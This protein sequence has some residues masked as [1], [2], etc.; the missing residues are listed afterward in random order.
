VSPTGVPPR[1]VRGP[2]S[3]PRIPELAR[4]AASAVLAVLAVLTAGG[5]PA[6]GRPTGPDARA[7]LRYTEYGI[8]HILARD[9]AGLG[10][11]YG[12]AEARDNIC[13]LAGAYLTVQAQRAR[14]FGADGPGDSALSAA[15]N[16]LDSDLYF[17]WI[18]DSGVVQRAV[19]QPAPLGVEPD[20]RRMVS[21][22][23]A[24]YN[25]YLRE[26]GVAGLPDPTCRGAAW[27]RPIT[28]LDVYTYA[29]ALTISAGTGAIAGGL[30]HAQPPAP[31]A[32]AV[33]AASPGA[34]RLAT[35]LPGAGTGDLGSNAVAVGAQGTTSGGAVLLG[36][37]HYPWQG[38]RRFWQSQLTIPGVFDVAGAGPFGLPTV[39][40][41]HN[42]DVAWS[43]TVSVAATFGLYEVTTVP[44]RPTAYLVDGVPEE[45]TSQVVSV[46]VRVSG[47][48]TTVVR[49]LWSTRYGPVI[50]SAPG[51]PLPW[52]TSAYALRDANA[53]NL[54]MLNTWLELGRANNTGQVRDALTRT[55]G[56]PWMNTLAVDRYGSAL[57]A[58]VQ[59]V[60]NVSDQLAG[61]CSTPLGAQVFPTSGLSIL[62]GGRA[63]CAWGTDPDAVQPGSLGPARLPVLARRDFVANSNDGPWL[64]NP[65]QPLTGFPRV[66]GPVGTR[67]SFRTQEAILAVQRRL[68][69]T[70]GLP[71]R[72][73]DAKTMRQVL[74]A[75]RSRVAELAAADT[76]HMCAAF[77]DGRADSYAG[78]VSVAPG[79]AAL[80]HWD[81]G[82][83]LDS[84]GSLLF[85]RFV[86]RLAAVPA[87]PWARP[88]DPADPLHTPAGLEVGSPAVRRAFGD[89]AADL[90][91]A[92]IPLDA[93]LDR[94]QYVTDG[95]RRIPIHG[96]PHSLGVL[97]VVTPVWDPAAGN[98]Q[99]VHGSSFIQVVEFGAG[100]YPRV[101]TVLTYSQSSDPTSAHHSDQT[102]LFSAGQWVTE[103]FTERDIMA[104]PALR[105]QVLDQ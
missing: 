103:R 77:P 34:A 100:R 16:S 22:Y 28:E 64:T 68:A 48:S 76:A 75:D 45:M 84:A 17:Q 90:R 40:I 87:A 27:V 72:G 8:P 20:V 38:S 49:R 80:A 98:T 30:V 74:L 71:G 52:S 95:P 15:A 53:G 29:Y 18:R 47:G 86:V 91:A 56:L 104:S 55:Q 96:A 10:L 37:P 88:F 70:D 14:Y 73:F 63:S 19:A 9:F 83:R 6:V 25:R 21:G 43:H 51:V 62:D 60:A 79:C 54:R 36:N 102:R 33:H 99:I 59:V 105:V 50:D 66:V 31:D 35:A 61:R 11:G 93:P 1:G 24:G 82:Y 67:L 5:A 85:E 26:T 69:G 41:G 2:A 7:T 4:A 42:A 32:P 13:V 57:F 44:G 89:A 101:S 12:Y 92:G 94:Y 65:A 46:R 23:V 3:R 58:D 78:P 81:G 97:N 39:A